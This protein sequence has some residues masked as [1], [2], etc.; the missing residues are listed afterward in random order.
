VL[1]REVCELLNVT[2]KALLKI[3]DLFDNLLGF[4]LWQ[5]LQIL[6]GSGL[7]FSRYT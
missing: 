2:D 1:W 5:P 6:D 3:P 7:Q 4:G